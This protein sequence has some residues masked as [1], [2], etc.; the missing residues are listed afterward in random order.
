M[1][2]VFALH[3]NSHSFYLLKLPCYPLS[4]PQD[5]GQLSILTEEVGNWRISLLSWGRMANKQIIGDKFTNMA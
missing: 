2:Y 1:I 3:I 5:N 4:Q